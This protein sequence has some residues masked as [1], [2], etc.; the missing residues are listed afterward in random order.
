MSDDFFKTTSV[1]DFKLKNIGHPPSGYNLQKTQD[2]YSKLP[3]KQKYSERKQA[4]IAHC[5]QNPGSDAIK[6]FFYELVRI[7]ENQGPVWLGL[8]ESALNYIDSRLDCSDFVLL[9]IMRLCFQFRKN[10]LVTPDLLKK[11]KKHELQK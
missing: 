1:N 7:S 9:G 3:F 4:F 2:V 6:G 11:A 10:P 5:L 8:I